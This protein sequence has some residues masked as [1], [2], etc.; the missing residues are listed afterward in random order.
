MHAAAALAQRALELARASC[1]ALFLADAVG[2]DRFAANVASIEGMRVGILAHLRAVLVGF[3]QPSARSREQQ[4]AIT[5]VVAAVLVAEAG[6]ANAGFLT[7]VSAAK[8]PANAA[9]RALTP[10][11]RHRA[12][13]EH[14]ALAGAAG[15]VVQANGRGHT[16]VLVAALPHGAIK[17]DGAAVEGPAYAVFAAVS[18]GTRDVV[19]ARSKGSEPT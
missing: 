2:V 13:S 5:R 4:V 6:L 14:A 17:S 8:A 18:V 7:R 9:R 11:F 19:D 12:V 15:R 1:L 16:S 10:S 3:T